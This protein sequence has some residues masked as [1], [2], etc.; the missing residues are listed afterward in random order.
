[1]QGWKSCRGTCPSP[2][3]T[4]ANTF[5][6]CGV[7][8]LEDPADARRAGRSVLDAFR[9]VADRKPAEWEHIV[10]CALVDREHP[11]L[12]SILSLVLESLAQDFGRTFD[13]EVAFTAIGPRTPEEPGAG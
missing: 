6:S 4:I 11:N 5:V 10:D 12:A 2:S 9:I 3:A 8:G 13:L 1:V 7:D